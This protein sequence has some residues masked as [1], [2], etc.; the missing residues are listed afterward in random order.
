MLFM[1]FKVDL[2]ELELKRAG[3]GIA[4]NRYRFVFGNE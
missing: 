4:V 2:T 1:G 3:V